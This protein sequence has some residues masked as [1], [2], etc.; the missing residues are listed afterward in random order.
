MINTRAGAVG[1]GLAILL[2]LAGLAL[3]GL[4][5]DYHVKLATGGI[6]GL[7]VTEWDTAP[8]NP[9][10]SVTVKVMVYVPPAAYE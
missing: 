9:S 4:L 1:V 8:V 6:A 2:A 7:T 10:L 3:T 5:L